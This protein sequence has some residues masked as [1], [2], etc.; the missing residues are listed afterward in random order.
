MLLMSRK[1]N[2]VALATAATDVLLSILATLS[3]KEQTRESCRKELKRS[4]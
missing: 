1:G 3:A 2:H 4:A